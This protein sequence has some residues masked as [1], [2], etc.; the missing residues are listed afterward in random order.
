MAARIVI[1]LTPKMQRRM[2]KLSRHPKTSAPYAKRLQIVLLYAEGWGAQR[3]AEALGCVPSTA[4]TVANQF[5][6]SGLA[7]LQ[8]RRQDNG[9]CKL[10]VDLLQALGGNP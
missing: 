3:I 8:D 1:H 4:V 7:G 9:A 2:R 10:D 6:Q 5:N